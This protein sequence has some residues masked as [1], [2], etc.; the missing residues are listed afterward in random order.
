MDHEVITHCICESWKK[1]S[2]EIFV[3]VFSKGFGVCNITRYNYDSCTFYCLR[4]QYSIEAKL[5]LVQTDIV[6]RPQIR[7]GF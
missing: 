4:F 7:Y 3:F 5:L 6:A 1:S 2:N